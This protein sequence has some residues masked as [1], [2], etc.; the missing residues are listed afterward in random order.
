MITADSLSAT[1]SFSV[2]GNA[3]A[4]AK[5]LEKAWRDHKATDEPPHNHAAASG[6]VRA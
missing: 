3:L 5:G 4:T 2:Q 1:W 6:N